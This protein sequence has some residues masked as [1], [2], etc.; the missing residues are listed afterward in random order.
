MLAV[1][2]LLNGPLRPQ[3]AI[4]APDATTIYVKPGAS[5]ANTGATWATARS[6]Q[7]ALAAA[8]SGDEIWVAKGL[9]IPGT[10]ATDTFQLKSGVA[11]YGGFAGTETNRNQRDWESNITVLSGDVGGDDT[12]D[13]NGV[14]QSIIVGSNSTHVV[15]ASGVDTAARLDGFIVTGGLAD[16]S[17]TNCPGGCGGG[18]YAANGS[19]TLA[20]LKFVVNFAYYGGG[21]FFLGV[22][23]PS[24]TGVTFDRNISSGNGGGL[25]AQEGA[26]ITLSDT[27]FVG[28]RAASW[29]GGA[30]LYLATARLE[31]VVYD[32]NYAVKH[33]GGLYSWNSTLTIQDSSFVR[34]SAAE[35][36]G[37]MLSES[38][39]VTLTHSTFNGNR[40]NSGGGM[41]NHDI[42][43]TRLSVT[44]AS[45]SGNY[46]SGSGG[47]ILN[48]FCSPTLAQ[49][50]MSG[51]VAGSGGAL[52]DSA[53]S[54]AQVNNSTLWGNSSPTLVNG[55]MVYTTL[56]NTI[57]EG[58]LPSQ[59]VDGG[60][61]LNEDPLFVRAPS[62]GGDSICGDI[63]G[64][65]KDES[66]DDDYGDLR[67][68]AGSPAVDAGK[69]DLVPADVTDVDADGNT[70]EPL[71]LD[72]DGHPR[73]AAGIALPP[74]VDMGAYE[75]VNQPPAANAGG[76]YNG[77]EGGSVDLNGATSSDDVSI[78]SYAWDCTDDGVDDVNAAA[79]TGS[80]CP[81]PDS[82]GYTVRL[83]A[84]DGLGASG[85]A[86]ADVTVANVA[87]TYK[88]AP[89][90]S[91]TA[92]NAK[93]FTMG[94]FTDP[95]AEDSW[96]VTVDWGD[97][98]DSALFN[99]SGPGDL[100]K[101][102]HAYAAAG[103]YNVAVELSD[104]E[105]KDAGGFQVVVNAAPPGA[106]KVTAP[107]AQKATAGAAKEFNL[108]S[109]TDPGTSGPWSV[110]VDW[111]DGMSPTQFN[112]AASGALGTRSH[113]YSKSGSFVVVV[114]VNDG[115]LSGSAGFPVTVATNG[116][117][118]NATHRVLLPAIVRP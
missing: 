115:A 46:A 9:Y 111:G 112:I 58:G 90:Q 79:P 53:G 88:S 17:T 20:N 21:A 85:S 8:Q 92:G 113:K 74:T 45:F 24:L 33:G 22:S 72:L 100:P 16:L 48:D 89:N 68:Q 62:C 49:V 75:R 38:S 86:T 96:S 118:G 52:Y 10:Q 71:P 2:L 51:N 78:A 70:A 108:G 103:T 67:L 34:N 40:A 64:T 81:Y 97:D 35:H 65:P 91:T 114:T 18:L 87:P 107:A 27:T 95:G 63:F 110:T 76:P 93:S 11:V 82:G 31:N 4:A 28:N 7:S 39:V 83:T 84:T 29:G 32:H 36:G 26:D 55:Y 1:A 61:N 44:G 54:N 66:A 99:A 69:N 30:L 117:G 57:L 42:G 109:F 77:T 25:Q 50:T 41:Y 94:S 13:A 101:Q 73:I 80:S 116:G 37:G 105:D 15:T 56:R 14:L 6:L 98:T 23:S 43:I 5:D 59:T 106:P 102:V 47:A 19:P 3:P 60:D 12:T 104:G